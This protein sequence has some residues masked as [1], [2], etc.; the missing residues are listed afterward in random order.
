MAN[1]EWDKLR[2]ELSAK[3]WDIATLFDQLISQTVKF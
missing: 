2:K 3:D 1:R